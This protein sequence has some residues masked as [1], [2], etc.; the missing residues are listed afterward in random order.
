MS[1]D[2]ATLLQGC[3]RG[4]RA[5]QRALYDAFAPMVMGV[6]MRYATSR[7]EA[8]DWLQDSFIKVFEQMGQVRDPERLP[9]WVRRVTVNTCLHHLRRNRMFPTDRL[10][11]SNCHDAVAAPLD[12]FATQQ[13]VTALQQLPPAQRTVFNLVE[14]EGYSHSETAAELHCTEVNVRALLSRA[15]KTLREILSNEI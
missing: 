4:Q 8:Q 9:A 3:R 5:S 11:D 2:F 12:P 1:A 14:V 10:D 15:K 13:V 7:D 6:C